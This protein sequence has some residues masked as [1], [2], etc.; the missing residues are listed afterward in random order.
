[1]KSFVHLPLD[2]RK[3]VI[4]PF[5]PKTSRLMFAIAAYHHI[6]IQKD[7]SENIQRTI[8]ASGLS[9]TLLFWKRLNK[10]KIWCYAIETGSI[11]VLKHLHQHNIPMFHKERF[12]RLAGSSGSLPVVKY[13]EEILKIKDDYV[14]GI[15]AAY[16]GH[17]HV[18]KYFWSGI[19]FPYGSYQIM[20]AAI[21]GGDLPTIDWL[22]NK[23]CEINFYGLKVAASM[24]NM[25]IFLYV[26]K[27][28]KNLNKF[29]IFENP[30]IG[31]GNLDIIK[32]WCENGHTLCYHVIRE[33]I[34]RGYTSI[35]S[36][37][38][39]K[40]YHWTYD[41]QGKD[42]YNYAIRYR[43]LDIL[44]LLDSYSCPRSYNFLDKAKRTRYP[45]II[46][47]IQSVS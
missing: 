11:D 41:S 29:S 42:M 25:D 30:L 3:Y 32:Y 47:Y 9:S 34:K 21:K 15:A 44:R 6:P 23:G 45:E 5:L 14:L 19:Q 43:R 17:L 4:R 2:I 13:L 18:L 33:A 26:Y 20:K 36:Y 12:A 37:L 27:L 1:M 7:F 31:C 22:V 8:V 28:L 16:R 40:G 38:L 24:K 10:E 35:L 46:D 39:K